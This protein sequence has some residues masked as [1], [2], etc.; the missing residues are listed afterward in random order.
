VHVIGDANIPGPM[1]K[2]G[3]IANSTAKQAVASAAALLRGETP[4]QAVYYNTC[5]SHVGED[6][7]ISVVGIFRPNAEGTAIVEVP[8]SGGVSP[9]GNLPDQRRLEAAYADAWYESITKDMFG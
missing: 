3:Y 5:Y 4:P 2:S 8:D 7:G 6:Y 9:R 1:P